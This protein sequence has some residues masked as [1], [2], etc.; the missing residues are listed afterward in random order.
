[1]ATSF[2][3][4]LVCKTNCCG[5]RKKYKKRKSEKN[6]IVPIPLQFMKPKPGKKPRVSVL[7]LQL[8]TDAREAVRRSR[9]NSLAM[10]SVGKEIIIE[11]QEDMLDVNWFKFVQRVIVGLFDPTIMAWIILVTSYLFIFAPAIQNYQE[12][13]PS[14][15][16]YVL[17]EGAIKRFY[18]KQINETTITYTDL[19]TTTYNEEC[20]DETNNLFEVIS[21]IM[22]FML[23]MALGSGLN[24]YREILV[25][26]EEIV[27]HIKALAM[28]M[29]HL[30]YDKQKYKY[31][32]EGKD[33]DIK[34][35]FKNDL[36]QRQYVKIKYLL[37][38]LPKVVVDTINNDGGNSG[39]RIK[40]PAST[41]WKQFKLTISECCRAGL[42][43]CYQPTF[44]PFC[45][46]SER[47]YVQLTPENDFCY[48]CCYGKRM[49]Y[50]NYWKDYA[51][52]AVDNSLGRV[53]LQHALYAKVRT[54]H[55]VTKMDAFE[56]VMTCLLD[57]L[58]RLNENE[59]GFGQ[60]E[61]SAVVS[62]V[63][64]RWGLIYGSWG[65]LSSLK[66][67]SE[68]WLVNVLRGALLFSYALLIPNRYKHM[69][70]EDDNIWANMSMLLCVVELGIFTLMWYLAY[71]IRNPFR[72]TLFIRGLQRTSL[73][74]QNQ[75]VNF[76]A[77][78]Y[79]SRWDEMDYKNDS[80][81]GW[82]KDNDGLGLEPL[83]L[84][85]IQL[86]GETPG[87]KKIQMNEGKQGRPA[88]R[89]KK[90]PGG[91]ISQKKEERMFV[92]FKNV[93]F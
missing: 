69:I 78:V 53:S 32:I 59:L 26:Y 1:M 16:K 33:D 74:T 11:L 87:R 88:K 34:L 4:K 39:M 19:D 22:I 52:N 9:K 72:P 73:L 25:L 75:V 38:A 18:Y 70:N 7:G 28:M 83:G 77:D 62:C 37:S 30:T 64:E 6:K 84:G 90:G 13:C 15:K 79:F 63:L 91:D 66:T 24:K 5:W 50:P 20:V 65:S 14:P 40:K 45:G 58:Q 23:T 60:D 51:D 21:G 35:T 49:K 68:P 76:L 27:G 46:L 43:R 47:S 85:K 3:A 12:K 31:H 17:N 80:S 81:Y 29:V 2:C 93:N 36:V 8:E 55:D 82:F 10:N 71:A 67:Y 44:S 61:G 54:I 89:I 42:C 56:C 41:C 48:K 92:K 86:E 57:E